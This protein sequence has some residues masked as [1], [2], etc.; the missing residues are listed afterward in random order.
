ML[1]WL[2][3]GG[4][5]HGMHLCHVISRELKV[6]RDLVRVLDPHEEAF[7]RWRECTENTGMK[8][9]RSPYVHQIDTHPFSLRQFSHG[10][11]ARGLGG[12]VGFHRRPALELFDAHCDHVVRQHGLAEMRIRGRATGLRSCKGGYRVLS[13]RGSLYAR[14]ILLA[15]GASE[16]PHWPA[17][18]QPLRAGGGALDHVF[19]PGFRRADLPEWSRLVVLGGGITAAQTALTLADRAPGQV[20]LLTR[21]PLRI[22]QFDSDPGWLGPRYQKGFQKE[23]DPRRRR[24]VITQARHRGSMPQDV[25]SQLRQALTTGRVEKLVGDVLHAR[26]EPTGEILLR[27][28]AQDRPLR[29]DRV[30]LATGFDAQRPGGAWLDHAIADL[31]LPCAPCGYPSVDSGLRW[32]GGI[33][34][35]GPLAELEIGPASRNIIGARLAGE[36]LRKA[37]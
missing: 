4:G 18:A 15:I 9:L 2:V 25:S 21:H 12:L 22:R 24:E 27:L 7:A 31:R 8:L 29:A 28:S 6:P 3:I 11:T 17:W 37:A 35:A 14:R 34:V 33:Y 26:L 13:D 16:Q 36:R 5:I 1:E 23:P 20:T 30:V 19:D 32:N 10:A